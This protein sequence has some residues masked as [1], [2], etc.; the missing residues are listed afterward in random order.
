MDDIKR[1]IFIKYKDS[2]GVEA[3]HASKTSGTYLTGESGHQGDVGLT[4]YLNTGML[5]NEDLQS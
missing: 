1:C 5:V 2:F 4:D 3:H